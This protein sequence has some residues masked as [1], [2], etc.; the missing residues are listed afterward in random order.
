M[1][2]RQGAGFEAPSGD[3]EQAAVPFAPGPGAAPSLIDAVLERNA[4]RLREIDGVTGFGT[5]RTQAGDAAIIVHVRDASVRDQLPEIVE[6]Y[7]VVV[8]VVPGGFG[9]QGQGG[10]PAI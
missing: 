4:P 6:G 7:P 2:S 1:Q 3:E 8:E 9:I 10:S 5:G